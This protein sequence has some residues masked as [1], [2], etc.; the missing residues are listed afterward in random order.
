[1]SE[2]VTA[3]GARVVDGRQVPEVGVWEIDPSH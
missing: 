3:P 2:A 1:M